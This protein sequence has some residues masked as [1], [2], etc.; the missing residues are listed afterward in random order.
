MLWAR[1]ELAVRQQ[2]EHP[3]KVMTS[4]LEEMAE[5]PFWAGGKWRF[6][7]RALWW[8]DYQA[9]M[10]VVGH[11][12]RSRHKDQ[13]LGKGAGL[14]DGTE[15][16]ESLGHARRVMVI[17]Y[18]IGKRARERHAG[19]QHRGALAAYQWPEKQPVFSD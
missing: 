6:E 10:A 1:A 3:V 13:H 5:E 11:Y 15:P 17:D 2:N 9:R 16:Y 7:R 19:L 8:Q 14:F 18:S 12:W 4:G